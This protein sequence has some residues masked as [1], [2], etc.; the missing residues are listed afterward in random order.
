MASRAPATLSSWINAGSSRPY[1]R[2]ATVVD[3]NVFVLMMSAP[4]SQIAAVEAADVVGLRQREQ[5]V[6]A[7]E[8]TSVLGEP[9]AT[10]IVLGQ[11]ECLDLAAART[12][13]YE[14]AFAGR[15]GQW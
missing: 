10:E 8:R 15:I 2:W 1:S 12:V 9:F 7:G 4:A 3:E 11:L 6:V 14:D 13:E 5:V